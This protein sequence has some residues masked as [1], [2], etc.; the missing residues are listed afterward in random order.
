[1]PSGSP[2][3]VELEASSRSITLSWSELPDHEQNGIISGYTVT[4][5][6]LDEEDMDV[7]TIEDLNITITDLIPYTTYGLTLTAHTAIGDGPTSE[8][9][10]IRTQE[11]GII[12]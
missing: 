4:I 9:H 8:L 6:D 5:T 3:V 2:K 11:E 10:V 1:M 7:Y 12:V